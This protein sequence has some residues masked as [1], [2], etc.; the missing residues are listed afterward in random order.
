MDILIEAIEKIA[1]HD[2]LRDQV[3]WTITSD[4]LYEKEI[5]ELTRIYPSVQYL[6]K[7]FPQELASLYRESDFLFMPSRFLETFGL[8]ALE[9][10][11]CGTPV[12]GFQK[13]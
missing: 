3:S 9:S 1:L 6:G 7:I 12:I 2:T 4:G 11:A 8:T 10:L 5:R 13:G